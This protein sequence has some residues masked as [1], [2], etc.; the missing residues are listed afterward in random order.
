MGSGQ[1]ANQGLPLVRRADELNSLGLRDPRDAECGD[2][3]LLNGDEMKTE[4]QSHNRD[5]EATTSRF[6][7]ALFIAAELLCTGAFVAW[8][9]L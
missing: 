6:S 9:V 7:F 4:A 8:L 1:R 2:N 5:R 3:N